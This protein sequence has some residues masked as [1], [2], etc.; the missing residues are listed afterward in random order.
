MA[1]GFNVKGPKPDSEVVDD[2]SEVE[3]SKT[4]KHTT[5]RERPSRA[6]TGRARVEQSDEVN[7]DLY[8]TAKPD[9]KKFIVIAGI[10]GV[11]II[12]LVVMVAISKLSSKNE[13]VQATQSPITEDSANSENLGGETSSDNVNNTTGSDA[14]SDASSDTSS[15]SQ[16]AQGDN[17]YDS[18]T[19]NQPPAKVFS[20]DDFVKDLDGNDVKAVYNVKDRKYVKAH[21][22]YT[23]HR[24]IIDDGMEMYWI[25]IV[26][27]KK[28]Y[29]CQVP[30]YYAKDFDDTGV[31]RVEIEILNLE[32]GG[33]IISYMQVID[34][35]AEED[36][37]DTG[38]IQ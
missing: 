33:E 31:C 1:I 4:I 30:F 14:T 28:K 17:N 5:A 32:G 6:N 2:L 19:A 11:C 24:A 21:V 25:D 37:E 3:N 9:N 38:G 12:A 16:Y 15:D 13:P 7:G 26:Y 10:V 8:D 23:L 18:S 36:S 34:E 22:S 35:E 29:R 20:S 27:K